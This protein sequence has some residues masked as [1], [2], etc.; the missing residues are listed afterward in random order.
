ML[1]EL[2]HTTT[3]NY[4]EIIRESVME[5]RVCPM[6]TESQTRL[7][8]DLAIGPA[9]QVHGYFDWLDNHVHAFSIND[10]HNRIQIDAKSIVRTE[11]PPFMEQTVEAALQAATDVWPLSQEVQQDYTLFDFLG[12]P[13]K[14]KTSAELLDLRSAVDPT[15][16]E[17]LGQVILRALHLLRDQFKYK[18]GVTE[19]DTPVQTFLRD[20][21]G[22]C[23]DF[24][25]ALIALLRS[26]QIPARYVSGI[27]HAEKQDGGP[28]LLGATQ[29]H[30]WA[31]VYLPSAGK[32]LGVDPTN[33]CLAGENFVK[34]AVGRDYSDV[35]P[36]RG[37]YLGQAEESIEVHVETQQLHRVPPELTAERF[38]RLTLPTVDDSVTF[39]VPDGL[40]QQQQQQQQ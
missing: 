28:A 5:L 4:S 37:V 3:L 7:S 22:V 6:Q 38:R 18:Q 40:Q 10:R 16:G 12:N 2:T 26:L 24:T 20:R 23:Q 21:E 27:L 29:T 19:A 39:D 8:F 11:Q 34:V 9:A 31:E 30:A 33:Q 14:L 15:E 17:P 32:W 1:I 13:S 25:H 35:P 36:N